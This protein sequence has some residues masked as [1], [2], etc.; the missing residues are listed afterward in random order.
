MP[1][2]VVEEVG[3]LGAAEDP[4][5]PGALVQGHLA[6]DV[7]RGPAEAG[8]HHVA[9]VEV[10]GHDH[11]RP[12]EGDQLSGGAQEQLPHLGLPGHRGQALGE[13]I[14]RLEL[15]VEL[16]APEGRPG[17]LDGL[18]GQGGEA[19]EEAG[20][21]AGE[22]LDLEAV[23]H[24]QPDDH[25]PHAD[26]HRQQRAD[27]DLALVP[28]Q[29]PQ[30]ALEVGGV[31]GLAPL[32]HEAEGIAPEG[33]RA[34]AEE[35]IGPPGRAEVGP[36]DLAVDV[37]VQ[38]GVGLHRGVGHLH[39]AA[40][41]LVELAGPVQLAGAAALAGDLPQGPGGGGGRRQRLGG[42]VLELVD[43]VLEAGELG[44]RG[45]Q[46]SLLAGQGPVHREGQG[47]VADG[48]GGGGPPVVGRP[49]RVG[50]GQERGLGGEGQGQGKALG[51]R[52]G[53]HQQGHQRPDGQPHRARHLPQR[54]HREDEE[55]VEGEGLGALSAPQA[56][57]ERRAGDP[58]AEEE[59]VGGLQPVRR[60][61][62]QGA[63]QRHPREHPG[64]GEEG[65]PGAP[66]HADVEDRVVGGRRF[67][68]GV[69]SLGTLGED[70]SRR[71][72]A[73]RSVAARHR[74]ASRPRPGVLQVAPQPRRTAHGPDQRSSRRRLPR[75]P[76]GRPG[77]RPGPRG[78]LHRPDA[79]AEPDLRGAPAVLVPPPQPR[80]ARALPADRRRLPGDLP[81]HR[82][83]GEEPRHRAVGPGG[84]SP[85][86]AGAGG[87][88]PG[89]RAA[90]PP[91]PASTPS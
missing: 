71:A 61:R 50:G 55:G 41:G 39:D 78:G 86:G 66:A 13:G 22:G 59:G 75:P 62:G 72:G 28:G 58:Q 81:G 51:H 33:G 34:V 48:G 10:V 23:G 21:G 16:L 3:L 44:Q 1:R 35:G 80:L 45:A 79:R 69:G 77:P 17:A 82:E 60:P 84:P 57:E 7:L 15:G 8:L 74:E 49:G 87:A 90:R 25:L 12:L 40:E 42:L 54:V 89:V 43:A 32:H 91:C 76:E 67:G 37:E 14:D 30:Q 18:R 85:G 65:L 46:P 9:G 53:S 27:L 4:R 70:D 56:G 11:R 52:L 19:P 5:R 64:Q 38:D 68:H 2:H 24:Q 83:G 20:L 31:E 29:V 63:Q 88:G 73:S 47:R 36:L 26:R 6:L